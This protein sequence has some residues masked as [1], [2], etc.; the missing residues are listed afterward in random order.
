MPTFK[1]AL[2]SLKGG[3]GKTTAVVNLAAF[4][5]AAG[6][7]TLLVDTDRQQTL[8]RWAARAEQCGLDAPA[9]VAMNAD[10]TFRAKLRELTTGYDAV[11]VDTA[12]Q[13]GPDARAVMAAA[14]LVLFPFVP[15]A[16]D[17]WALQDT[18]EAF[19]E[20]QA[21]IEGLEGAV[22]L[23]RA[24]RT[25]LTSVLTKQIGALAVPLLAGSWGAR[26]AFGEAMLAGSA[27]LEHAPDSD[28][29]FEVRTVGRELLALAGL[30]PAEKVAR[31]QA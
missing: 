29:A 24:G 13:L 20:V 27:V 4:F 14:D 15:G 2:V 28:A 19:A 10:R 12:P 31:A 9:V 8:R 17:V 30:A 11:L 18:L 25:T 5:R 22:L 21:H 7:R 3:S 23:N 16:A 1:L 6:L 26:V